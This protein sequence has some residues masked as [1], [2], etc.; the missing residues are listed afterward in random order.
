MKF[1]V[2]HVGKGGGR[3]GRLSGLRSQPDTTHNT[4]LSL[5]STAGGSAPHLTQDV[6]HLVAERTAPLC[7]PAQ[8]FV[9]HIKV[10]QNFKKGV[11][12]FASLQSHS[13]CVTV[14]DPAKATPNGYNDKQG[15]SFWTYGGRKILNA[16]SYMELVEA[17]RPDWYEALSDADTPATA[18]KKRLS[19]SLASSRAYIATCLHRHKESQAFR[20]CGV[21]VPLLGGHSKADRT[22]WI[23]GLPQLLGE[24]EEEALVSGYALQG[25][26]TNGPE[27]ELLTSAQ[28]TELAG[29]SLES[30][31]E[32]RVRQAG[33]GWSP[34]VVVSLVELGVD[35]FD[36][37]FPH[38]VTQRNGALTF[39]HSRHSDSETRAAEGKE[40]LE[41]Q[42]KKL[43]VAD[44]E[45]EEEKEGKQGSEEQGDE[46]QKKEEQEETGKKKKPNRKEEENGTKPATSV[47]EICLADERYVLDERPLL[48]G[49]E[50]YACKNFSRAYVHH[51]INVKEMLAPVLLMIHNLHH[52]TSFF[53][54]IREAVRTDSLQDLKALVHS[55]AEG[56]DKR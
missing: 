36:S 38:L 39:P 25:L 24:E 18:S 34:E 5:I 56:S 45:E 11:A 43:K 22:R 44:T 27:A 30:L 53:S 10:L 15:I 46:P 14:H 26:H 9:E 28:V 23:K 32:G 48:D 8:H 55:A 1:V 33:G 6:L 41:H 29:T 54:S 52:W 4:P 47:Y 37:S 49:C 40:N 3:L 16:D 12:H 21:M 17:M 7:V 2:E 19:K 20:G 13:V 42:D 35:V 50:C 51:L 31:P